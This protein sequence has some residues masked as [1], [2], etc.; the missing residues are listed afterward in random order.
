M[1]ELLPE[2]AFRLGRGIRLFSFPMLNGTLVV[3][4]GVDRFSVYMYSNITILRVLSVAM[5]SMNR[6]PLLL[7]LICCCPAGH[8]SPE[9]KHEAN[10][11]NHDTNLICL[12]VF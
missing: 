1:L 6:C 5:F 11:L 2:S 4:G 3:N 8:K 10:N 12:N 9:D 7:C